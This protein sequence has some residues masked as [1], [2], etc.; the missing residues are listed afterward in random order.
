MALSAG[1]GGGVSLAWRAPLSA[2]AGGA[3]PPAPGASAEAGLPEWTSRSSGGEGGP[4]IA[5]P[6][7]GSLRVPL[8]TFDQ[9]P[10][11][12]TRD[13]DGSDLRT[14]ADG[15]SCSFRCDFVARLECGDAS[16]L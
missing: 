14:G 15:R 2:S 5:P 13:F 1:F 12:V 3:P 9:R 6:G 7:V 10:V 4:C 11:F 8:L 16:P